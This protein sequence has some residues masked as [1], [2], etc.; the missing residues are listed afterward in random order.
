MA[1]F[2]AW[3]LHYTY[4]SLTLNL[5]VTSAILLTPTCIQPEPHPIVWS[6]LY[7][8]VRQRYQSRPASKKETSVLHCVPN[9]NAKRNMSILFRF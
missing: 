5:I 2:T 6:N 9:L 7:P 4:I 8:S 3:K 1:E